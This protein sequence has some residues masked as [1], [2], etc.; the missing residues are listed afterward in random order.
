MAAQLEHKTIA[1]LATDG[2]N[3]YLLNITRHALEA[4]GATV[5][6]IGLKSGK[7]IAAKHQHIPLDY[8]I[9]NVMADHFDALY[10]P[11]GRQSVQSLIKEKE[12]LDFVCSFYTSGKSI[13]VDDEGISILEKACLN[14]RLSLRGYQELKA[15]GIFVHTHAI[16]TVKQFIKSIIAHS[17]RRSQVNPEEQY[18]QVKNDPY[19]LT[20]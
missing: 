4:E 16:P 1:I 10:I 20:A 3:D 7:I 5:R 18:W 15:N 13:A 19:A 12:V 2:V 17:P 8:S 14:E 9:H 6:I 11:G